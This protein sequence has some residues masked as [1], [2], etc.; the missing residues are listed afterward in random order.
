MC[1]AVP[2]RVWNVPRVIEGIAFLS[3]FGVRS[4]IGGNK[5]GLLFAI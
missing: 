1:G 2:A 3:N 5:E 4:Y